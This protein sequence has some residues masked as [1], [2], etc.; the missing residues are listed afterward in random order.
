MSKKMQMT[1]QRLIQLK[2]IILN[3]AFERVKNGRADERKSNVHVYAQLITFFWRFFIFILASFIF[4]TS[5]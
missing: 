2:Q 5:F 4:T 3:R 1:E